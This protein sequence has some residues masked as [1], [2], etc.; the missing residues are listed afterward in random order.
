MT[1]ILIMV[2]MVVMVIMEGSDDDGNDDDDDDVHRWVGC[3]RQ[4]K[5]G[6]SGEG[7]SVDG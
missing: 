1:M 6:G 7:W 3:L 2:I 4:R 5:R